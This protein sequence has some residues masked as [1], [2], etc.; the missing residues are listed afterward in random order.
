MLYVLELHAVLCAAVDGPCPQGETD[1]LIDIRGWD[2]GE[3]TSM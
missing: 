1:I 2:I 3:K